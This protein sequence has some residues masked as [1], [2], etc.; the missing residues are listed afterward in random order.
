M[1]PEVLA[2]MVK[3][4]VVEGSTLNWCEIVLGPSIRFGPPDQWMKYWAIFP[5][6]C[7][8]V[9]GCHI[10]VIRVLSTNDDVKLGANKGT[11]QGREGGGREGGGGRE[12]IDMYVHVCIAWSQQGPFME[13]SRA[14]TYVPV[15]VNHCDAAEFSMYYMQHGSP[16]SCEGTSNVATHHMHT[17]WDLHLHWIVQHRMGLCC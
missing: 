13:L 1:P 9:S 7:S 2:A 14:Y 6:A 16:L 15:D 4:Y 12:S 11:M 5:L 8:C 17:T 3:L 10:R